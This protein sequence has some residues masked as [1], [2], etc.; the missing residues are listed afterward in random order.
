MKQQAEFKKMLAQYCIGASGALLLTLTAFVLVALRVFE[1][2]V[3]AAVILAL[4]GIQAV[5]QVIYFLHLADESKPRWNTLSLIFVTAMM[6]IIV[7]ASLWIMINLNY[8]MGM[9]GDEMN[10]YMLEQN[11]KG[12]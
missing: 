9:S 10:E 8:N 2:T 6:L 1:P 3:I 11:K 7:I 5:V 4:A 12:F